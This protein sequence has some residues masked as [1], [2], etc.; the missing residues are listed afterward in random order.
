MAF[1]FGSYETGGNL[2]SVDSGEHYIEYDHIKFDRR[3][4]FEPSAP[5]KSKIHEWFD[6]IS[7][8]SGSLKPIYDALSG[9]QTELSPSFQVNFIESRFD[10]L[11]H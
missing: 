8:N 1:D 10:S 7:E 5:I 6:L 3:R 11:S 9:Q 4:E 2:E